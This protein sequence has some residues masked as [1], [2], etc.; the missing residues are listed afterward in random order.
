MWN[1]LKNYLYTELTGCIRKENQNMFIILCDNIKS[2]LFYIGTGRMQKFQQ[3][4]VNIHRDEIKFQSI[5]P[6]VFDQSDHCIDPI[7]QHWILTSQSWTGVSRKEPDAKS[8]PL[9]PAE[10]LTRTW[11]FILICV[12]PSWSQWVK[13]AFHCIMYLELI[14]ILIWCLNL[15]IHLQNR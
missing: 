13:V 1:G 12:S 7:D 2:L 15:Y 6:D 4:I 10:F 3:E 9:T 8:M 11:K 5:H 14:I